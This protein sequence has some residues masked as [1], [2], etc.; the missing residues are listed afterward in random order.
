MV[1]G[2]LFV[3]KVVYIIGRDCIIIGIVFRLFILFG[4]LIEGMVWIICKI[5][6]LLVFWEE[7]RIEFGVRT[8][9]MFVE[10]F[11][12]DVEVDIIRVWG[13]GCGLGECIG[14][15]SMLVG[16]RGVLGLWKERSIGFIWGRLKLLVRSFFGGLILMLLNSVGFFMGLV[17]RSGRD[18]IL[19]LF[20]VLK[21]F[22]I[23]IG[24]VI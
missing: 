18:V 12:L 2:F 7:V 11:V 13:V 6:W 17:F 8:V 10:V 3:G 1:V 15:C 4:R 21:G 19:F 20:V 24:L 9:G 5:C 22:L 14:V 16:W 23:W